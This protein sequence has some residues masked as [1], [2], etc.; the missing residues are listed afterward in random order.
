MSASVAL[1]RLLAA[2]LVANACVA[3]LVTPVEAQ[4]KPLV[5]NSATA[6]ST[7]D[8]AWACGI[9]E[10]SFIQN[11]YVRLTQN[12][13]KPSV[14][15]TT[16]TDFSKVAPYLAK[17]WTISD[18]LLVY[19]FK[20]NDNYK[21]PSGKPVDSAAVKYSFERLLKMNGCGAYFVT[22]GFESP[23][24]IKS[25]ETPDSTTIIITLIH[26][27]PN[28]LL[29][30]STP[31]TS[32]V[33]ASVIEA[34][35]GVEAGK[36]N[37]YMSSHVAGSGP[38][39]L[40]SYSANQGAKLSANPA[41][42]GPG[43]LAKS[44]EVNWIGSAPTL[45]LQARTGNADITIG[46]AKQAAVT[47]KNNPATRVL[48]YSNP[49]AEQVI[50][51][52]GKEPWKNVKVREA[53]ALA[54]PYQDIVDKVA[55]GYGKLYFGPIMPSLPGFNADL[56]KPLAFDLDKAKQLMVESG[57]KTPVDV[58]I[59]IH[60]GDA[61]QQQVATILQSTWK[62]IGINLILKVTPA[63]QFQDMAEGHK[64]QALMRLDGP[65]V[66]EIG[67]FLGYDLICGSGFNLTEVCIPEADALLAKLR[68][69]ADPGERQKLID[70]ITTLWRDQYPKLPLFEDEPVVV[71]SKAVKSF[72]FS[73]LPDYRAWSK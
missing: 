15:G 27:D 40:D 38:F 35:G 5:V 12:P 7:L 32:I 62:Q 22:D 60:E 69:T 3:A 67:Y 44:I 73:P 56:S 57:E 68:Q 59:M 16:E 33:D 61:V 64:A 19:T 34:N 58:E 11:F 52:N 48:A 65:G 6:P 1:F 18:D 71:L 42:P 26:P 31:A 29:D 20:L 53:A 49:F 45:L 47:L 72:E 41:F 9:D 37:A 14:E 43:P 55:Y 4:E 25:I 24:L 30:W 46:L 17:S 63:A 51:P 70:L 23:S 54:V 28:V 13:A 21:F 8:P 36:P 2:G 10:I 50:I 39:L 66:F